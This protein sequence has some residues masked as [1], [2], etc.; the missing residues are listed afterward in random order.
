[1][2]ALLFCVVNVTKISSENVS[3]LAIVS[4]NRRNVVNKLTSKY[5]AVL[6]LIL[7]YN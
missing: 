3:A 1:M 7:Y 2:L 6:Q 5:F 4:L